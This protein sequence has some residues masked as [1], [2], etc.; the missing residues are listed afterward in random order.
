[1]EPIDVFVCED[2]PLFRELFV[3]FLSRQ[4]D[5]RIVGS[6]S[7]KHQLMA[8][9]NNIPID[10]LVL[11]INLTGTNYD[12]L[13]AAI[14]IKAIQPDLQIIV[15]SSLDREDVMLHAVSYGRVS[16]Y[17]VKEHYRDLPE[18][19]RAAHLR[20]SGL[21]HSSAGKLLEQLSRKENEELRKKITP[22]QLEILQLLDQGLSRKEI[23]EQLFYNEQSI[24]NELCKISNVVKGKFPYLEWLRLKKHNTKHIIEL[25]KQLGI[26]S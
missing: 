9:V 5:I 8:A 11:D 7:Y 24:N 26:L 22:K 21:H 20:Q 14:E 23:A 4:E 10:V 13:E 17:I 2:D 12:G 16:N 6:A 15:L 25:A 3:N 19:I 1:M 18:A